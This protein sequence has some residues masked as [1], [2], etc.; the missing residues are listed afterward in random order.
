MAN[1]TA[2][3]LLHKALREV[4]GDHVRQAGLGGPPGQAPLRLHASAGA[5][6]GGAR[7]GSSSIVNEKVFENLPVRAFVTPI[8]EARKLGAMMLFGEKYGDEVRVVEIAGLL[9]RAL[10]RH[11]CAL[12]GRDRAVRDPLGGRRSGRARGG[13]RR[14]RPARRGRYLHGGARGGGAAGRA[15][16]RA[17]GGAEAD[18]RSRGRRRRS[19]TKRTGSC[20]AEVKALEGPRAPRSLRPDSPAEAGGGVI[21]R[22]GRR[23]AR[24]P[25]RQPRRL[26]RR[27]RARRLASCGRRRAR[28]AAAAAAGRRWPRRAARIP[29]GLRRRA[30]RPEERA[31]ADALR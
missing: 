21:A 29:A 22:L 23:R 18:R 11:A 5:D 24:V 16:A 6:D 26:A 3:H 12:D 10:R 8:E 28:S 13:S 9:A 7:A 25:R 15:Q 31:I 30:A 27:A 2:T 4:L 20:V 1:H 19:R 17:Q 14:S